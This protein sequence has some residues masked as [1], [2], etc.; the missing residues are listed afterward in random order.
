VTFTAAA[1][2]PEATVTIAGRGGTSAAVATAVGTTAVPV[3][4]DS[5]DG[6]ANT[7][8]TVTVRRPG[9]DLPRDGATERPAAATLSTTSGWRTGLHD[10]THDV[11]VNLWWGVNASVL[12]LYENDTEIARRDL[13]PATPAAQHATIPVTG[14]PNG[15]Y[16]YTAELWNQAGITETAPVTVTVTD[17][18]PGKPVL[19]N[20]NWDGDGSYGVRTDMWWG[21]NATDYLLYE[22]GN[23]VDTRRLDPATP[24]AQHAGTPVHGRPPGTYTYVVELR[25]PAGA[26]RSAPM[27]VNVTR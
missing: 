3:T 4:V 19:S 25:N 23:L 10:G 24:A 11:A 13:R 9:P 27:T 20:D 21:T 8:Y 18:N 2:N 17:A 16:V 14:R 22:N 26:T 5:E 1:G 6:T 7:T 15:T 12:V